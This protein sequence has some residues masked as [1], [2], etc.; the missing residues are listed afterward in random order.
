MN[1]N[2]PDYYDLVWEQ[3]MIPVENALPAPLEDVLVLRRNGSCDVSFLIPGKKPVFFGFTKA[4]RDVVKWC[5]LPGKY[6]FT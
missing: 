5:P 2:L 1:L 4:A 3:I 6:F